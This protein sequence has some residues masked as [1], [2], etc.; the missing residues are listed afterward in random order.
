MESLHFKYQRP[1]NLHK[2]AFFLTVSCAYRKVSNQAWYAWYWDNSTNIPIHPS[3]KHTHN[4]KLSQVNV[5][6]IP[7][8]NVVQ[9]LYIRQRY[10][11]YAAY[12]FPVKTTTVSIPEN[13]SVTIAI[14]LLILQHLCLWIIMHSHTINSLRLAMHYGQKVISSQAV[15][16]SPPSVAYMR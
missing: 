16:S 15:N 14:K 3:C 6:F 8:S 13:G 11:R 1:Y 5:V 7:M 4:T 2:E 10:T 12:S 9:C